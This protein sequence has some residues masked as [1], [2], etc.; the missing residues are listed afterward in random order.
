V[1]ELSLVLVLVASACSRGP[2]VERLY[3]A[4]VVQGHSVES[5]AYAAFL[6][7]AMAESAGDAKEAL[8]AFSEAAREDPR[9]TEIWT[10]IAAARCG[11][12]PHDPHAD[13]ALSRAL[14]LDEKSAGALTQKAQCAMA[15]GDP[16]AAHSA[17][18]RAAED[19]SADAANLL[20]A[21][22]ASP[23]KAAREKLA[24]LTITARDPVVAWEGLASWARAHDDLALWVLALKTLTRIAPQTRDSVASSAQR[25]AGMGAIGEARAVAAAAVDAS[26][27]PLP[28]DLALAA[29]LS[30]DDAIAL[31]AE[32]VAVLRAARVRVSEEEVAARALL[33]GERGLAR[34]VASVL[35]RADPEAF[36]ARVVLAAA[37]G[38]LLGIAAEVRHN[39]RPVSGAA[40]VA[41]GTA[42]VH[43]E[44]REVVRSA[45]AMLAHESIETG[46]DLVV[47]PAVELAARGV[48]E[49][50]ALPTDGRVELAVLRGEVLNTDSR[51]L[52]L[53]HQ[54]LLLSF[55]LPEA[56]STR[57]LG[58]RLA[59]V[60]PADPLV[61]AATMRMSV[62]SGKTKDKEAARE[63]LSR[64]PG[65]PLIGTTALRFA[66]QAGDD[67]IVRRAQS[68]LA[69]VLGP[70]K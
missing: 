17:A 69:A 12:S 16:S 34:E 6:R 10:R 60:A 68:G 39:A 61:A 48:I 55:A 23:D 47:R 53:R 38:E 3:G 8:S 32:A 14:A 28:A 49:A 59:L 62:V 20:I 70:E 27:R 41:L 42:M 63:L 15:R 36:G 26:E 33:V 4:R 2:N 54:A 56:A 37:G 45:L 44:H 64:D 65:D 66:Q 21:S 50:E 22:E 40:W 30:V 52:D 29:R 5:L 46:D 7:G 18:E 67:E 1:K 43:V 31:R 35:L 13:E 11:I 57:E 9:G 19:P 25:L 51:L 24:A 58:R